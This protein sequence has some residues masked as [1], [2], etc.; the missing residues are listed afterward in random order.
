MTQHAVPRRLLYRASDGRDFDFEFAIHPGGD[1]RI[2]VVGLPDYRGRSTAGTA[3]H[4][5]TD[6]RG[7][8]VCW[9]GRIGSFRDAQQVAAAWAEGTLHYIET[10]NFTVPPHAPPIGYYNPRAARAP[11]PEPERRAPRWWNR[12]PGRS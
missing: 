5:Y 11:V 6:G 4:L 7:A 9:D 12:R 1:W 2:Y 10:G 3:I 8:Y